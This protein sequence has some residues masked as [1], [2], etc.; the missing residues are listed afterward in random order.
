MR[1]LER[2]RRKENPQIEELLGENSRMFRKAI[3]IHSLTCPQLFLNFSSSCFSHTQTLFLTHWQLN[4]YQ[5]FVINFFST[6][7]TRV[8]VVF[9]GFFDKKR[10]LKWCI[11][12]N[13]SSGLFGNFFQF[14]LGSASSFKSH[15]HHAWPPTVP[16]F[17]FV[18]LG[19]QQRVEA[20]QLFH[21]QVRCEARLEIPRVHDEA[22]SQIA[23]V[24]F[25]DLHRFWQLAHVAL[26]VGPSP[27]SNSY[28]VAETCRRGIP[29]TPN[30][31]FTHCCQS[32]SVVILDAHNQATPCARSSLHIATSDCLA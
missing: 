19:F 18:D 22:L 16:F 25:H 20:L 3:R 9:G 17:Q 23:S 24:P 7:L 27:T 32:L 4:F 6:C 5:L 15:K 12:E 26:V 14:W 29:L 13:Y 31:P 28:D 10:V 1:T 2:H 30:T 11:T 21:E 8:R